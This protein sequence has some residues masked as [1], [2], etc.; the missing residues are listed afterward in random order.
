[1]SGHAPRVFPSILSADL[2]RLGEELKRLGTEADGLH[3]DIMDGHFVPNLSFGPPL[4]RAVA[5]LPHHP[6]LDAHLMVERPGDFI[7]SLAAAGVYLFT[8]HI[9]S[10]RYP[11]RLAAEVRD[12]GMEVGVALNPATPLSVL[13]HLL[14]R[15]DRVLLM[16][17]DPGFGGQAFLPETLPK[18][19]ALADRIRRLGRP[20]ELA[21]DGGINPKTAGAVLRA[22]ADVLVAGSAVFGHEDPLEAIRELRRAGELS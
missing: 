6:R 14:E 5:S 17:V 18:I 13:D 15:V 11:H 1:M 3:L 21:V 9:E 19:A 7:A 12:R 2:A 8:F 16:T 10:C 4:V 20:V 22:G